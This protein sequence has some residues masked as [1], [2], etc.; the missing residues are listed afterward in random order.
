MRWDSYWSN[1]SH[2]WIKGKFDKKVKIYLSK[3]KFINILFKV[4][5]YLSISKVLTPAP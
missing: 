3:Q 4:K 5:N 1:K 2:R